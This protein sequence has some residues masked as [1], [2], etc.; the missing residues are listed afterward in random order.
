M[1]QLTENA[2][3]M[4]ASTTSGTTLLIFVQLASRLF[5]FGS[6]QIILRSLSPSI[7]GIAAQLELLFISILYFSRESI[8]TAIQRQPLLRS[9][10]PATSTNKDGASSS[11]EQRQIRSQAESSQSVVNMSYLGVGMGIITGVVFGAFYVRFASEEVLETPLYHPSVAVTALASLI[12]LCSEPFF[13]VVQQYMLYSKR[14]AVEISAVFVKSLVTCFTSIWASW[15]GRN[16]GVLPFAL[17]YLSYSLMIF[18][19]YFLAIMPLSREWQFSFLLSR[20]TPS[21]KV[22]YV[23][24]RWPWTLILLSANVFFQSIVKHLLTQGDSMI[25]AAMTSLQDQGIYSLTSNYGGLVARILFQ[26]IEES[27]RVIFSSLL[28]SKGTKDQDASIRAAKVHLLNVM[29]GYL[30]ISVLIIPLGPA[31]I[32]KMLHLLG[33]QRW[34]VPE[35]DGLLALYCYYIPFLAFNGIGE[36]FVSSTASPADLRRQAAWM[37]IFSACFV[38]VAYIFLAVCEMGAR[39]LVFA[40]IVNMSVRIVW[41][42]SFVQRYF[43]QHKFELALHEFTLRPRTYAAT[44]TITAVLSMMEFRANPYGDLIQLG[45]GGSYVFLLLHS[46]RKH[47]MTHSAKLYQVLKSKAIRSKID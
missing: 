46:E 45:L 16:L 7:L 43:S 37:G 4:L 11:E 8:R 22:A 47:I 29:R 38:L 44:A 41:S 26:P 18:C 1:S 42:F 24:A 30:I 10:A 3:N 12:E 39:G 2:S 17:G 28:S 27:S 33:G 40:N 36:A 25:L 23:A 32:P 20:I 9:S 21:D 14:A 15:T 34:A 5:I 13:A 6:N 31:L 35:V 19:G